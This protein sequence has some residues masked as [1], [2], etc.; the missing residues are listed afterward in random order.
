MEGGGSGRGDGGVRESGR[1]RSPECELSCV[2]L[3]VVYNQDGQTLMKRT[4]C[5]Q[6]SG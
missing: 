3:V 4:E 1:P 5:C 6:K 2:C